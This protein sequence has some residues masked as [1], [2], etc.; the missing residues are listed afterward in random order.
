MFQSEVTQVFYQTVCNR[1][2]TNVRT[3]VD[4]LQNLLVDIPEH[5]E[6]KYNVSIDFGLRSTYAKDIA[7][8]NTL[9]ADSIY[10][11]YRQAVFAFLTELEKDENVLAELTSEHDENHPEKSRDEEFL[12][13]IKSKLVSQFIQEQGN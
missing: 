1:L 11:A 12:N 2:R 8:L 3:N 4:E 10:K 6:D 7:E 5:L 9:F 13:F